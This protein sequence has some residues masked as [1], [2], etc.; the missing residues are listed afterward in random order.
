LGSNFDQFYQADALGSTADVSD[1]SGALKA[2]YAYD[3]WGRLLN[4]VDP[5][6]TKNKFKFSGEALDPTTG[7]YCM[8]AR[9]YDPSLGRFISRDPFSGTALVPLTSNRYA[10]ALSNP[11][12]LVD[13]SGLAAE[14]SSGDSSGRSTYVPYIPSCADSPWVCPG[15]GGFTAPGPAP[16]MS[17]SSPGR[18]VSDEPWGNGLTPPPLFFTNPI[19]G[20]TVTD[21]LKTIAGDLWT[22][23]TTLFGLELGNPIDPMGPID[24]GMFGF[25]PQDVQNPW[26][27]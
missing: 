17:S 14:P 7:L 19:S 13:P 9:C 23:G 8:R 27:L 1:G 4:P 2:V 11:I 10:Y 22:L 3:P 20:Q 15:S 12:N 26:I 6:G 5:L 16:D 25:D 24:P 21:F 18:V